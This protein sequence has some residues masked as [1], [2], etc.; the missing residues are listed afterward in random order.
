MPSTPLRLTT[1]L[2]GLL[3][4]VAK[5]TALTHP[6]R[7][8]RDT[9]APGGLTKQY[10]V[11]ETPVG[12]GTVVSAAPRSTLDQ[13]GTGRHLFYLHGGA[14]TLQDQHWPFLRRFVDRGWTVH[15]VDYPLAPEHTVDETV[16]M[17]LAAWD[18]VVD[19]ADGA[20]VDLAGDSAGGGL[21]LVLL[22]QLRDL[23]VPSI[24]RPART[25]LLSPWV[26]AVMDDPATIAAARHD[27][28]LSLRGLHGCV[29]LYRGERDAADPWLSPINGGLHDLGE[30]QTWVGTAE[31][32]QPQCERLAD[33][34]S[35][36]PGTELELHLGHGLPHDWALFP[37][38][39][40]DELVD[41]MVAFL[42]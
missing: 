3:P 37:T 20:P 41:E 18:H 28:L 14:Y 22:Q 35:S 10:D 12:A 34:A 2:L 40:R 29:E 25:V 24:A 15:L 11:V 7:R 21:A 8:R 42:G 31:M 26:E 9:V 6:L 17:T 1:A 38:P 19:L 16:P 5:R 4:D 13:P 36:A 30:I 39:E 32:F 23:D 33:D 27:V